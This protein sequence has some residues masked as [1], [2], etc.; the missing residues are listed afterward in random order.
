MMSTTAVKKVDLIPKGQV[1]SPIA[2]SRL[3][4]KK[5]LSLRS[6]RLRGEIG[7][8]RAVLP[9]RSEDVMFNFEGASKMP[10][11]E[12][13]CDQCENEFENW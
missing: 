7:F 13:Q 1:S 2:V 12:Y 3:E 5:H 11:F 8:K 10:I 6:L 4:Q 9:I